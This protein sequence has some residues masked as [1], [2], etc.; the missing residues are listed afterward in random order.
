MS[1]KA[2]KAR[3]RAGIPFTKAPKIGTPVPERTSF[4]GLVHRV[5]GDATPQGYLWSSIGP[6][7]P[8]RIIQFIKSGG[9]KR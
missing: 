7:S 2:R 6:R 4:F 3:K 8:R 9:I 5:A 1:T